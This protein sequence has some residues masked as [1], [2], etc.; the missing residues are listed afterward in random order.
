[1]TAL[2]PGFVG[3]NKLGCYDMVCSGGRSKKN[4]H[5]NLNNARSCV[6]LWEAK[7]N[8]RQNKTMK[9]ASVNDEMIWAINLFR[10]V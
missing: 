3:K 1:M 7:Q 5:L 10:L 9:Q 8:I 4:S 2:V 6:F